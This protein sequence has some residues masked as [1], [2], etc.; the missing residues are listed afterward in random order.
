MST[1]SREALQT[2]LPKGAKLYLPDEAGQKRHVEEPLLTVFRRWGYREIVTPA[3]AHFDVLSQGT[4][5]E[6]QARMF[7][8]ADRESGRLVAL[9]ADVTPQIARI[10]ATRLRAEP[11]PLRPAYLTNAFR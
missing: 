11:N 8:M 6:L 2:Q 9:R 4:D 10:V 7:K 5:H 3:Y 1:P